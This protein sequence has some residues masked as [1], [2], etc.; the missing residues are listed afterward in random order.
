MDRSGNQAAFAPQHI[1]NFWHTRDIG[2]HFGFGAGVRYI[3]SQ[4]IAEDNVYTIDGCSTLDATLYYKLD[5]MRWHVNFKNISNAKYEMRGF[6]GYA[7]IPA[8]PFVVYG[9]VEVTL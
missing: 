1:V 4:F 3:S 8:A 9:G 6:G 5:A 2:S 7:V